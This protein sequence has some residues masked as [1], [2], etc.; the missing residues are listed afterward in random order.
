MPGFIE[1]CHASNT[2][3]VPTGADWSHEIK[4]DG[5]RVQA[6]LQEGRVTLFTRRGYDWTQRFPTIASALTELDVSAAILDGEV[7]VADEAGR[8]NFHRL[9]G[10]LAQGRVDR[11]IY[12]AF[13]LLYLNGADVTQVGLAER[14]RILRDI[15]VPSRR[16]LL[17]SAALPAQSTTELLK[18]VCAVELEGVVSKR[19]DAPYRSGR[20]ETWQKIKCRNTAE[21]PIIAFVEKLGAHPR[22]IASLYLGRFEGNNLLYAGKAQ[23]G[24]RTEDL[25]TLRERL[26]PYITRTSPLSVAVKKPKATWV[27]PEL[28]AEVQYSSFTAD[29]LLRAPVYKGLRD[30]IAPPQPV[31]EQER[32][33]PRHNRRSA[34]PNHNILQLLPQAVSPVAD[35]LKTYWRRAYHSALPYLQRRPLK[36]V[37]HVAGTTFYHKGSLPPIPAAVHTLK[38]LKREGG[39]GTRVWIDD[40]DGLLGLVDMDAV[41]VHAWNATVDDIELADVMVFDLDP[42]PGVSWSFVVDTAFTLRELLD[43]DGFEQSWPKLTGGKGVHVMVPLTQRMPHD[44]AHRRSRMIAERLVKLDR[45]RYTVSAALSVRK[46]RLFLD[47]LRNGRGTT[48]IGTF[49]PRARAGT[50]IAAPIDWQTL[51]R[52]IEPDAYTIYTRQLPAAF[53]GGET[54]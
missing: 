14:R 40:L 24:F 47:Y 51:E 26:D 54:S 29:G 31:I 37:R 32:R 9:Q 19:L 20:Q 22:R 23:T 35:E 25:F 15:L 17:Y 36:L 45:Q 6:H 42:G 53:P 5:Y 33:R 7:V 2:V 11:L 34:V 16:R 44:V 8:S 10:D 4:F 18:K 38:V 27:R 49:S 48:A 43:Q 28:L 52:G 3:R 46:G 41:E 30:D 1:P 12:A 13:D 50:P 21:F 39:T